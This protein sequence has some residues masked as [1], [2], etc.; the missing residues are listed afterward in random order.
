LALERR[1]DLGAGREVA[2]LAARP[3]GV[4]DAHALAVDDHDAAA[5]VGVVGQHVLD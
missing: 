3:V 1:R 4:G 5:R 2:P